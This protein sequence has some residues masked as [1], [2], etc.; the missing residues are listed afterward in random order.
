MIRQKGAEEGNVVVDALGR[1]PHRVYLVMDRVKILERRLF[2]TVD[3]QVLSQVIRLIVFLLESEQTLTV[4][5][6]VANRLFLC[7]RIL[8]MSNFD[9]ATLLLVN[10]GVNRTS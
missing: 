5:T 2:W 1:E 10:E 8:F 7:N 6:D 3:H 9:L 4:I